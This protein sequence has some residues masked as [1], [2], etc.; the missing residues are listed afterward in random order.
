MTNE[1]PL[2]ASERVEL[3]FAAQKE[4][5]DIASVLGGAVKEFMAQGFTREQ[6][7]EIVTTLFIRSI[8]QGING[9]S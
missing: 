4:V 5:A 1:K 3:L 7:C 6:A 9:R 2:S 8:D